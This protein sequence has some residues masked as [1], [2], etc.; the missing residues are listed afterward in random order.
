MRG[1]AFAPPTVIRRLK[2]LVFTAAAAAVALRAAPLPADYTSIAADHQD[3]SFATGDMVLTGH[4]RIDY[5]DLRLTA[6]ELHYNPRTHIAVAIGHATLTQGPRRLLADKITYHANDGT[7]EVGDLRLGDFPIYVTGAGA[8]G[9]VQTKTIKITDARLYVTEPSSLVPTL[10]AQELDFGGD[11][12]VHAESAN[13]GVG[14]VRPVGFGTYDHDVRE[15]IVSDVSVTGGYRSSLGA[16][17]VFDL[18]VPV[19]P[20]LRLGADLGLYSN[21]GVL[22]GPAGSY[23]SGPNSPADF[24][25]FFRSGWISDN[26][27]RY[28]DILGR[29]VPRDRAFIQWQQTGQLTDRLS[30]NLQLNYWRDSEVLRDFRPSDF[31]SVQQPDTYLETVYSG[32]NYFVSLFARFQPN[33]WETVQ[34]RLPELR[35][36]LLPTP[37]GGGFVE[38]FNASLAIL[39]DDPPPAGPLDP[40]PGP[41]LRSDRADAFY[42]LSRPLV[43][44][45]WFTLTPVAG[46][47]LTYYSNLDGPKS[48]YTRA[49]GEVGFDAEMRASGTWDYQNKQWKIDGLRHLLTPRISYRYIPEADKGAAYIPPIDVENFSTYLQPLELGDQRNIDQLS[50]TNTLRFE[51]DNTLQTRDPTYGSRDLVRLNVADDF[52]FHTQPG[53]RDVSEIHTELGVMPVRWLELSVYNSF[54][55]QDWTLSE[56]NTGVTLRNGDDWT[57]RFASNFLRHTVD[58]YYLEGSY[59]LNEAYE[60]VT[61]L[62]YDVRASRFDEQVY[63]IRQNLGNTWRVEYAV[64]LY[65]GPR[66]ESRFGFNLRIDAIRF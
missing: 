50:A 44:S 24:S 25:G 41:T 17:T 62:R 18:H 3:I 57:L 13:L 38:Q 47:R 4:A 56:I 48:D 55:P 65:D 2:L 11:H 64:T 54:A 58:D 7:Y 16:F 14:D 33:T 21:R 27:P 15:P 60:V 61:H 39:R 34:Q 6:E 23:E 28:T 66:R 26:G 45:E 63:G 35:F 53:Q 37:I 22:I 31:F 42:S 52:L 49:L 19:A 20:D 46:G 59:H 43:A 10:H 32:D 8:T 9:S 12:R 40:T 29:P 30:L 5:G 36:D 1:R 51:L